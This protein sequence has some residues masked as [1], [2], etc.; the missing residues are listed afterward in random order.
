MSN[1]YPPQQT[2]RTFKWPSLHVVH[3]FFASLHS[4]IAL[5]HQLNIYKGKRCR[6]KLN[7][8]NKETIIVIQCIYNMLKKKLYS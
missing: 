6:R 1:L 3:V 8:E 7:Y 4:D 5:W 2:T